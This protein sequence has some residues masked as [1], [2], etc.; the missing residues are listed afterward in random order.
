MANLLPDLVRV[1]YKEHESEDHPDGGYCLQLDT[2]SPLESW[3]LLVGQHQRAFGLLADA[4]EQEEGGGWALTRPVLFAAHHVCE[5]ALKLVTAADDP[6]AV[7]RVHPLP[8][9][10]ETATRLDRVLEPS[11]LEWSGRFIS[12]MDELTHKG[13]EG[14]YIQIDGAW[15]CLALGPLREG[16][17]AFVALCV[18]AASAQRPVGG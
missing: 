4:A 7:R 16:V 12:L 18:V 1:A 11:E 17:D 3:L 5:L 10:R 6:A 8:E 9:L 13:F 15:C 14:R 2:E